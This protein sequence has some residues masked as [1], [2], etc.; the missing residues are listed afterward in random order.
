MR[1][2]TT[3]SAIIKHSISL[4]GHRT[5]VSLESEFWKAARDI[6]EERHET[7]PRLLTS[8]D[9]GRQ[10][11]NLSSAIRL[12]VLSHY[13]QRLALGRSRVGPSIPSTF[14]PRA[15]HPLRHYKETDSP[16]GGK[17]PDFWRAFEEGEVKVI[18]DEPAN[19]DYHP[20]PSEKAVS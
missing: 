18:G 10:H 4:G 2:R 15:L 14:A 11:A 20:G 9:A 1:E 12:F 8:I 17:D 6:A 16:G 13:Q 5:S 3:K 19:T 7:V